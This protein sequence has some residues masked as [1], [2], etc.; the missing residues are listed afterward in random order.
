[1]VTIVEQQFAGSVARALRGNCESSLIGAE[2][3]SPVENAMRRF[4]KPEH[5]QDRGHDIHV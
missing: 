2:K 5:V 1:M 4:A 3:T